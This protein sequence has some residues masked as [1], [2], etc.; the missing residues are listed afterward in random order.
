[1]ADRT[2][3]NNSTS[4]AGLTRASMMNSSAAQR[5]ET[6]LAWRVIMDCRVKPGNDSGEDPDL[7]C[8]VQGGPRRTPIGAE[9]RPGTGSAPS[10]PRQAQIPLVGSRPPSR[11]RASAVAWPTLRSIESLQI[12]CAKFS[13]GRGEAEPAA[14]LRFKSRRAFLRQRVGPKATM[15]GTCP[16][17]LLFKA[18]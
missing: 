10:P 2:R 18:I 16:A 11:S 1:M 3:A 9:R 5:Y 7:L 15:A 13:H 6:L 8:S 17:T 14:H 12:G 4:C